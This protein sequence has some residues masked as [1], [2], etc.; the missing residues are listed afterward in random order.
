MVPALRRGGEETRPAARASA[1]Q[2]ACSAAWPAT[3]ARV[4]MAPRV[5]P[6]LASIPRR[7]STFARPTSTRGVNWRRFMLG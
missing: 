4:A 7:P 3:S 2:R 1:G 5:S 6:P